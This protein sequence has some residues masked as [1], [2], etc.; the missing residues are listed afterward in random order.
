MSGTLDG[1]GKVSNLLLDLYELRGQ[2]SVGY[3]VTVTAKMLTRPGV[4]GLELTGAVKT[5]SGRLSANHPLVRNGSSDTRSIVD[6]VKQA[7]DGY[8]GDRSTIISVADIS[9]NLLIRN[10]NFPFTIQLAP[11]SV[12]ATALPEGVEIL[13]PGIVRVVSGGLA[14]YLTEVGK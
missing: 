11:A 12:Y 1:S 3:G 6:L 13:P 4:A 8:F 2:V 14:I 7:I 9:G 10:A 5:E